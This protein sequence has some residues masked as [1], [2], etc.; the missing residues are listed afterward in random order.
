MHPRNAPDCLSR[1]IL[2]T[3]LHVPGEQ[4]V[5]LAPMRTQRVK[6][7]MKKMVMKAVILKTNKSIVSAKSSLMA[8]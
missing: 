2:V 5:C 7:T 1:H 8:K 4:L 3:L 6:M